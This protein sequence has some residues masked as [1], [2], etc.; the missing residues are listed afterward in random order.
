M[1]SLNGQNFRFILVLTFTSFCEFLWICFCQRRLTYRFIGIGIINI[2]TFA[3]QWIHSFKKSRITSTVHL[4]LRLVS[5][6]P[7]WRPFIPD[8]RKNWRRRREV[9]L[10][11][12]HLNHSNFMAHSFVNC[13]NTAINIYSSYREPV[14]PINAKRKTV[15]KKRETFLVLVLLTKLLFNW[16]ICSVN[17]ASDVTLS[18]E[19]LTVSRTPSVIKV[20]FN[21]CWI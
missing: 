15:N 4:E 3:Y 20:K 8:P 21:R 7:S 6:Y 10:S 17:F 14:P 16:R 5:F 1:W 2:T 11:P 19:P 13:A 18:C 12:S 9:R